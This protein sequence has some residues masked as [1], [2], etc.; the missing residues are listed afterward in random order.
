[1]GRLAEPP[2]LLVADGHGIAH[3]RRFGLAC[4]LGVVAGLPTIGVAKTP[5]GHRIDLA[6]A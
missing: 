1:M 4:H 5:L 2:D 6:T 3:P